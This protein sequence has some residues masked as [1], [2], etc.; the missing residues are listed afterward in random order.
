MRRAKLILWGAAVA[1]AVLLGACGEK[2]QVLGSNTRKSD[3]KAWDGA[4][5]DPF[6]AK[7]WKQGDRTSWEEQ[8]RNRNQGQ[9]EYQRTN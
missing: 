1:G 4:P 6:V 9:N 3:T 7:G 2:P 5:N 8:L